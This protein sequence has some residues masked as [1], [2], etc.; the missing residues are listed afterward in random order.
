MQKAGVFVGTVGDHAEAVQESGGLGLGSGDDLLMMPTVSQSLWGR[1]LG[2][3]PSTFFCTV[4]FLRRLL[5][6]GTS[7][8]RWALG[9]FRCRSS[10][11]LT[12]S[13]E[14]A[15][16]AQVRRVC[17]LRASSHAQSSCGQD[18]RGF[19]LSVNGTICSD[20]WNIP[21][22]LFNVGRIISGISI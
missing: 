11:T 22:L 20:L 9:G 7:R 18:L 2:V 10:S 3:E 8:S 5:W 12:K 6:K 21:Q 19:S 14:G 13:A 4:C 1:R 15:R 17:V 16:G